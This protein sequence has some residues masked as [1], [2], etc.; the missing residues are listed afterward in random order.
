MDKREHKQYARLIYKQVFQLLGIALVIALAVSAL[1]GGGIYRMHALC[2]AGFVMLCWAWFSYLKIVGM[3]PFGRGK[4]EKA[5][6]PYFHR[7][8][9]EQKPHRPAFRMDSADFDDDL[10]AATVAEAENFTKKQADAAAAIAR[11]ICG[12]LLVIAS[13]LVPVQ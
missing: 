7:R 4:K 5:G 6:V 3:H 11:A 10:T 13:F 12:V 2:A 1:L 8:F 9:K